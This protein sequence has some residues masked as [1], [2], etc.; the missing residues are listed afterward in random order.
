MWKQI[1]FRSLRATF[2]L[3]MLILPV[4][5]YT[6]NPDSAYLSIGAQG[7]VGQFASVL[8][9]CSGEVLESERNP[10]VDYSGSAYLIV[11]PKTPSPVVLGFR[12]GYW[13]SRI[14]RAS[15]DPSPRQRHS[16]TYYNPNF[17]LE[18]QYVGIGVGHVFGHIPFELND[19]WAGYPGDNHSG[20]LRTSWHLRL[21]NRNKAHLKVSWGECTPLVSG[22]GLLNIG[23][24]YNIN[25]RHPSF[26]GLSAGFYDSAGFL[27]QTRFRLDRSWDMQV[28]A[29][30]GQGGDRFEGSIAGGLVYYFGR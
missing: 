26:I 22:G 28:A 18:W 4:G 7:G 17:N 21:G 23:L 11:P 12:Y 25:Y 20:E 14:A 29:R 16:F 1:M 13:R 3:F 27:Y 9:G 2:A 6:D 30:I 8:R 15:S 5:Y 10:Y 24:G 19:I